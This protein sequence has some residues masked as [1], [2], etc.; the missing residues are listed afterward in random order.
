MAARNGETLETAVDHGDSW[1]EAGF[2]GTYRFSPKIQGYADVSRTFS[3]Q[4]RTKWQVN[5][6]VSWQ[7]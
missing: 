2:G 7:F 5:A 1:W 6:G 4:I 3:S